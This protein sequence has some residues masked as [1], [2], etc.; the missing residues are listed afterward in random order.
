MRLKQRDIRWLQQQDAWM[1]TRG[2]NF[3]ANA[4]ILIVPFFGWVHKCFLT[5][6]QLSCQRLQLL[7]RTNVLKMKKTWTQRRGRGHDMQRRCMRRVDVVSPAGRASV[8]HP[9][10]PTFVE[11]LKSR[12]R[13]F[14]RCITHALCLWTF[15]DQQRELLLVARGRLQRGDSIPLQKLWAHGKS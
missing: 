1:S 11:E 8:L 5:L 12:A 3:A 15:Q 2:T 9:D 7:D 10:F 6:L 4:L 14:S 13:E